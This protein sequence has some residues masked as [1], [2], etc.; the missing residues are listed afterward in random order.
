IPTV[1]WTGFIPSE[2]A[3]DVAPNVF[4]AVAA[5]VSEGL[6]MID[7]EGSAV[8]VQGIEG[9]SINT[10]SVEAAEEVIAL[11]PDVEIVGKPT[12][13]FSE[14]AARSALTTFLA[15]HPQEI[16][17]VYQV[18]SMGSGVYGAFDSAGRESMPVV[19][20][21]LASAA[22]LAWW[23]ELQ[24]EGY[25]G[26]ATGGNG[27]MG[28]QAVFEVTMRMANGEGPK[29]NHVVTNDILINNDNI[30]EFAVPDAS[31]TSSDE[32][33]SAG[34]LLPKEQTDEQF[35]SPTE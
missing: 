7:G 33:Q 35:N 30:S 13:D 20:D 4:N 10:V 14:A 3:V 11:C 21:H 28:A 5:P 24:D 23:Q 1:T 19:V 22:S 18:A 32:I 34:E 25:E 15:T 6:E 2:Y 8:I 27:E 26:V 16:D 29:F 12:G 17:L 31:T 9:M